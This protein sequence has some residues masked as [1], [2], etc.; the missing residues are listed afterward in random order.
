MPVSCTRPRRVRVGVDGRFSSVRF[1]VVDGEVGPPSSGTDSW[2][3]P[4]GTDARRYPC[5]PTSFQA[6]AGAYCYV[7]LRWGAGTGDETLQPLTFAAVKSRSTGPSSG[8]VS[9]QVAS[10]SAAAPK[11]ASASAD[12]AD[13]AAAMAVTP[14]TDLTEDQAVLVTARGLPDNGVGEIREC[15]STLLQPVVWIAGVRTLVSCTDPNGERWVF[16]DRGILHTRFTIVTGTVGPPKSG[17]DNLGHS[18]AIDASNYPCPPTAAEVADGF[19][20]Y[21][22]IEWG[23]GAAH[24]VVV[25]ITFASSTSTSATITTK[26]V[27]ASNTPTA[28]E[29]TSAGSPSG[30]VSSASTHGN[31]PFTGA[32]I[33]PMALAGLLLVILGTGLLVSVSTRRRRR[34]GHEGTP[35]DPH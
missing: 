1:K 13:V 30:S 4:A 5:Q 17:T 21:L 18:A 29:G 10:G 28:S 11:V 12:T 35:V 33:E 7:Q 15:N 19:D 22:E 14:R 9:Q 23:R 2:G 24:R 20:C 16:S 25:P 8:T 3:H 31:L 27:T 32:S 26:T 34:P 6:S